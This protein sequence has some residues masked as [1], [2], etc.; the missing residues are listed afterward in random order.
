M[1]N[2][3]LE[4]TVCNKN[5]TLKQDASS[6]THKLETKWHLGFDPQSQLTSQLWKQIQSYQGPISESISNTTQ[7]VSIAIKISAEIN[8]V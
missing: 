2:F 8:T 7:I 6:L 5:P 3:S 1:V 4:V